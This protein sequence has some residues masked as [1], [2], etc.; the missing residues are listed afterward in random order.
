[1]IPPLVDRV[2]LFKTFARALFKRDVDGLY[3]IVTP[4]F[5]WSYHDGIAVVK[6][7]VGPAAVSERL[8]E[9]GT[10]FSS[11][12]F[13]EAIYHQLP[14]M[15]IMTFRVSETLRATGEQR[16]QRGIET[17]TFRDGRIASKDVYR[18]PILA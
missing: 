11:Q 8:A 16:E 15:T 5:V 4:D 14:E 17:Y 7:L 1:M 12:V 6:R 3:K 10:M 18:K 9:Q 13:S 2:A